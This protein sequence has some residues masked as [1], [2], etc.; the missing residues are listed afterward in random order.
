LDEQFCSGDRTRQS[1]LANI[2]LSWPFPHSCAGR[3]KVATE[4]KSKCTVSCVILG[5]PRPYEEPMENVKRA[6]QNICI[7]RKIVVKKEILLCF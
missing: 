4:K 7:Q 3:I 2:P 1:G 6:T 5:P